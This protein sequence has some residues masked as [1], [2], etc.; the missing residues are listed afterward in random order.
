MQYTIITI[1]ISKVS[2]SGCEFQSVIKSYITCRPINHLAFAF[3]LKFL[4]L[5]LFL[6][7]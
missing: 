1:K 4:L 2:S 6:L 7:N 3:D 5:L